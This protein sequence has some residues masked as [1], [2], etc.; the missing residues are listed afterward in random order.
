MRVKLQACRRRSGSGLMQRAHLL[1]VLQCGWVVCMEALRPCYV[2]L[3]GSYAS[4]LKAIP[5]SLCDAS[6]AGLHSSSPAASNICSHLHLSCHRVWQ[7]A[8]NLEQARL[9]AR[10]PDTTQHAGHLHQQACAAGATGSWHGFARLQQASLHANLKLED[11]G[12]ACSHLAGG[13]ASTARRR[14]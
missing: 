6:S 12:H 5:S 13:Q 4:L 7:R 2:R 11:S 10:D 8:I 1:I 3:G 14:D 9:H